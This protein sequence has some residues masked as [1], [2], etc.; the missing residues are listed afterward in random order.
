VDSE[1]TDR[2]GRLGNEWAALSFLG[3][4]WPQR[5]R[6]MSPGL[7]ACDLRVGGLEGKRE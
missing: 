1:H 6:S 7:L 5:T 3:E 4:H 2:E